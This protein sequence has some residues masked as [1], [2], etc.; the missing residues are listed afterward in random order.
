M[1]SCQAGAEQ[2]VAALRRSGERVN[3]PAP[4]PLHFVGVGDAANSKGP[5]DPGG[6][7]NA[8]GWGA[9]IIANFPP[10]LW[11]LVVGILLLRQRQPIASAER[12]ANDQGQAAFRCEETGAARADQSTH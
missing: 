11:F 2:N 6:F 5:I 8:G 9:A 12:A 7:Y 3:A 10:L 4:R 1:P